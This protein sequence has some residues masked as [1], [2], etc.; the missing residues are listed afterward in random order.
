M[1]AGGDSGLLDIQKLNGVN[2]DDWSFR[3]KNAL[4]YK[5]LWKCVNSTEVKDQESD[6][7]ALSLIALSCNN[8]VKDT[9]LECKTASE[10]WKK[11]AEKYVRSSPAAKVA[12]YC[13]LT[14]LRCET[15]SGTKE[16]LEEFSVVVRKLRELKVTMDDDM[17]TIILLRALPPCY[18]QFRV[19]VLTRDTLPELSEVQ[20]KV[21]EEYLRQL[22]GQDRSLDDSEKAMA[23]R[24]GQRSC[25]ECGKYGHFKRDCPLRRGDV[26]RGD[27][28]NNRGLQWKPINRGENN[29]YDRRALFACALSVVGGE[30]E[31]IIDSGC[32]SHICRDRKLF[33][34]FAEETHTITLADGSS[35]TCEGIG[36]VEV[37]SEYCILVLKNTLY[38]PGL[39][40]NFIS[41]S[42]ADSQG[43]YMHIKRGA[44]NFYRGSE[45][46]ASARKENGLYILNKGNRANSNSRAN[47]INSEAQKLSLM[48]WHR[49]LGH[50]NYRTICEMDR[51]NQVI[52]LN[53]GA[54]AQD[55]CVSC[56]RCKVSE[57]SY[58]KI[59]HNRA[60]EPLYRIHSD[61][62]EMPTRSYGGCKYFVTFIDD[63]SRHVKVYCIKAKSDVMNAWCKYQRLME[64]QID[65]KI[66]VLRSDNGGEY[67]SAEFKKHL[68]DC[69]ITHE[70]SVP[71]SPA[72]NGVAERQ[73]RVLQEMV[74]CMLL[75]GDMPVESWA[76]AVSTA[77]Y[78][79]NRVKSSV[80]GCT[81]FQLLYGRKPTMGHL[82]R[83]GA[84][85]VALN[86]GPRNKLLPKGDEWRMCGYAPTQKGYRLLRPE[87]GELIISRDCVFVGP[88]KYINVSDQHP[89]VVENK[90]DQRPE[91]RIN[92]DQR[93][94][95][96]EKFEDCVVEEPR[97]N[98]G[99]ACKVPKSYK[100]VD[101]DSDW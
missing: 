12:L 62:C 58:P 27:R 32:T 2:Y 43:V 26:R 19:A 76:E 1:A 82:Q 95:E 16:L 28:F 20:S 56:A 9:I 57:E 52:G 73:N 39:F 61:V 63:Y 38:V 86:K 13:R 100:E 85:V 98:P 60:V 49:V 24:S 51:E 94:E 75:D 36:T 7:Q 4:M 74:R 40:S 78:L 18:E 34:E 50:V 59:T 90:I 44:M 23:V 30:S 8:I 79:R 48:E 66:K 5:R 67:L 46:L 6:E 14:S 35:V 47:N 99:R 22:N 42:Q 33:V 69:G 70:T 81:P 10:A 88:Q 72:Q 54:R 37:Q 25:F 65:A 45:L 84:S 17:F 97:R 92:Q 31:F 55:K 29:Y 3:V 11:L 15:V 89:E 41:V 83:F 71:R 87:T 53:I 80:T 68:E 21:E 77:V 91:E 96:E 93:P 64:R 101:E